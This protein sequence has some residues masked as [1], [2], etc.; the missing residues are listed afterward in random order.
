MIWTPPPPHTHTAVFPFITHGAHRCPSY[1]RR[2]HPCTPSIARPACL[3]TLAPHV[4]PR[5]SL[6]FLA[7]TFPHTS[8]SHCPYT[9]KYAPLQPAQS[10]TH[11]APTPTSIY[12][13][14]AHPPC[15]HPIP[16]PPSSTAMHPRP[17][18]TCTKLLSHRTLPPSCLRRGFPPLAPLC[19]SLMLSC[20]K[21]AA[22]CRG[23]AY[24]ESEASH[25]SMGAA[26]QQR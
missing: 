20:C 10:C 14:G 15:L 12:L 26:K 24:T 4:G 17:Y 13:Y 25:A 23:E 5:P 18:T 11:A 2:S 1:I 16:A 3:P 21:R 7:P 22:R 8:Q 19:L 9:S 6:A